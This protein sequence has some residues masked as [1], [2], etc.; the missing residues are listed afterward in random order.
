MKKLLLFFAITLIGSYAIFA[1]KNYK[2]V[3]DITSN[4][5]VNQKSLIRFID[6]ILSVEPNAQIEAVFYAQSVPM[7]I[8]DR[9]LRSDDVMRVT[10]NKNVSFRV[11]AIALKNQHFDPSQ[12]LTGVQTVPDGIYEIIKKQHEGWGYIKVAH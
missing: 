2:V 5:S 10:A 7:V 11:C 8:R 9:S 6:E 1:Q 4:D 12:L 3:F